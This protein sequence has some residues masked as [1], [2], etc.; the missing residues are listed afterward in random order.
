MSARQDYGIYLVTDPV[1]CGTRGVVETVRQ[2][3]SGGVKTVQL[4]DK[5]ACFSEQLSQLKQLSTV[6]SGRARLIINDRIDVAVAAQQQGIIFDGLHVGQS[7]CAAL[8]ARAALGADVIIGL[9]VH[10]EQHLEEI[11]HLPAGTVDYVGI[12]VIRPTSTKPDHSP[13]L[14]IAGFKRLC[15]LS[16]VPA[17]A[18]GGIG[19]RDIH[20]LRIAGASGV[21]MVSALCA[22]TDPQ[23]AAHRMVQEW[24]EAPY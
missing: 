12:G 14:G 3:V 9:S 23:K 19:E 16:P 13:A 2:A 18:I 1:L 20:Q 21:A 17:V 22:A 5:Q 11:A 24:N 10:T 4:R 6:I 8:E 7:D 15:E